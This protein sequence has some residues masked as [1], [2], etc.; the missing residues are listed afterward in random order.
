M[1]YGIPMEKQLPNKDPLCPKP[2]IIF[3]NKVKPFKLFSTRFPLTFLILNGILA[4]S[5]VLTESHGNQLIS[6]PFAHVLAFYGNAKSFRN[7]LLQNAT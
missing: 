3:L 5:N 4:I 2:S 6:D 1:V 7:L